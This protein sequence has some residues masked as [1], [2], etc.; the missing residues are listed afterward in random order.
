MGKSPCPL[1]LGGCDAS[2]PVASYSRTGINARGLGRVRGV[3]RFGPLLSLRAAVPG[4]TGPDT[5]LA[6]SPLG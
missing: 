2:I 1:G 4:K 6:A 5:L 3:T